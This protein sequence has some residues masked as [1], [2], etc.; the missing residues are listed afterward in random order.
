MHD[1]YDLGSKWQF[2]YMY[3]FSPLLEI[4]TEMIEGIKETGR[5]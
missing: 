2:K 3:L 4:H 1:A 5:F